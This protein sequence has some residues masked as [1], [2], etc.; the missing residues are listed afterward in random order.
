MAG[1]S[2]IPFAS[3][4][5]YVWMSVDMWVCTT[6]APPACATFKASPPHYENWLRSLNLGTVLVLT[7]AYDVRISYVNTRTRMRSY[8]KCAVQV[9]TRS[10]Q[11]PPSSLRPLTPETTVIRLHDDHRFGGIHDLLVRGGGRG[12][13]KVQARVVLGSNKFNGL[14]GL[15]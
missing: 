6:H 2:L 15:I 5:V 11:N 4:F 13:R 14:R 3:L 9:R 7:T 12:R 10:Q 8:K 1:T